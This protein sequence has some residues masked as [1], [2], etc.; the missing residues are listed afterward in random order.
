MNYRLK[1][2]L[3]NVRAGVIFTTNQNCDLCCPYGKEIIIAHDV[4]DMFPG[5]LDEYFEEIPEQLKMVFD[6]KDGDECWMLSV[7]LKPIQIEWRDTPYHSYL[8]QLGLIY[9]TKEKLEK[10]LAR[11][12]AKVI[13]ERDTKGFK[14]D[15]DKCQYKYEVYYDYDVKTF[16]VTDSQ[17]APSHEELWFATK[18]D[19]E[20]S[21]RNHEKEWKIYLGVEE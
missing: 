20:K 1:K 6:L 13:L 8:R 7:D 3:R 2:G 15:W 9:L 16:F 17:N 19:A 21:I 5:L 18:D 11:R 12:K 10:E 4:F 14:P